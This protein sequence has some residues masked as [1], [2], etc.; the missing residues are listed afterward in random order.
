M[1]SGVERVSAPLGDRSITMAIGRADEMR[2]PESLIDEIRR[3]SPEHLRQIR[4]RHPPG[5]QI[6]RQRRC[7]Q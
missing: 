4:A 6:T 1:T 7:H 3:H 2:E 5:R